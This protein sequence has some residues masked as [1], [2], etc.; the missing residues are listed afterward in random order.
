MN[1][2]LRPLCTNKKENIKI[3]SK[4]CKPYWCKELTLLWKEMK[5]KEKVFLKS[6]GKGDERK[7]FTNAR[8]KFDKLLRR[9][10]RRYSVKEILNLETTCTNNPRKFWETL[11]KIRP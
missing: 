10:K 2:Y 1:T 3:G 11:K 4:R 5:H 8:N 9:M 7:S 6:K